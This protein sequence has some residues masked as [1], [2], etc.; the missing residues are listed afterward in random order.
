MAPVDGLVAAVPVRVSESAPPP[1]PTMARRQ[2]AR[3]Q[4]GV[5][6]IATPSTLPATGGLVRLRA[7]V[8][9]ATRCR[10]SSAGRLK[11]LPRTRR[12]VSGRAS[13]LVRV[14]RNTTSATRRYVVYLTVRWGGGERR[15]VRKVIVERPRRGSKA[16]SGSASG[17][18]L[19]SGV[20]THS[21]TASGQ[22]PSTLPGP[23]SGGQAAA[24]NV[25]SAPNVTIQPSNESAAAGAPVTLTAAASGNP[26]P[27]VQWQASA[28]GGNS[29]SA[30]SPSF[31]ASASESGHEYRA[32]FS[33]QAGSATSN[34]VTLTVQPMVTTNFSGYITYAA[35]GQTFTS[36]TA[37]WVVPTVTCAP[38][39]TSWAAQWPGIG[40]NTT[41]QQDGTETDCFNGSPAY[42][43][44]YEMYG[45]PDPNANGG[46]AIALPASSYPVLP[47]D[48]MTGT[49]SL[50]NSAW[51]LTLSDATQ[52]WNFQTQFAATPGLSQG[53]A[54]WMVEDPN[55][56]TPQCEVLSQFSPVQFT[57]ATATA[58]GFTAPISGFP[59]TAMQIVQNS[60][61][62]A[63]TG[64]LD[65]SGDGFTDSW[66]AG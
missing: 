46:Y 42:W 31:S 51:V 52:N 21:G 23:L 29:W 63:T 2:Q 28:D 60:N 14:P 4:R 36:V 22:I 30:T 47:D 1:A 59:L 45:D 37:S 62:L 57:H 16:G 10:F 17:V 27:T 33:N 49:V 64:P 3:V 26:T 24:A 38:A 9:R 61:A 19:S 58:N 44:W 65:Q 35:P 66:L 11:Q 18:T 15:T 20:N 50:S 6:L 43:A 53:S 7:R 54:E 40:D 12:C 41:V 55:G 39:E 25:L 5:R 34:V 56:C 32:V 8:R 48:Q 13:V